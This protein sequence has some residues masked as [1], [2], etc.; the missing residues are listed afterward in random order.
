[1]TSR[2]VN[3]R[4]TC[5]P[6]AVA[7]CC[8]RLP[9][10]RGRNPVGLVLRLVGGTLRR[11][12]WPGLPASLR[13]NRS[14]LALRLWL[15]SSGEQLSCQG[16]PEKQNQQAPG[17]PGRGDLL[18]PGLPGKRPLCPPGGSQPSRCGQAL[19]RLD[20]AHLR[21]RVPPALLELSTQMLS[22]CPSTLSE[23]HQISGRPGAWQVGEDEPSQPC[24][25]QE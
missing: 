15:G 3:S 7:L 1:M 22:S 2:R 11:G 10:P 24:F 9:A 20:G 13:G 5:A 21:S 6:H 12:P 17:G 25:G 16:S 14:G 18:P 19:S 8:T 4:K 23:S